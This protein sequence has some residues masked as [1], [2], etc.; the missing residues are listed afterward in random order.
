MTK[1]YYY[2]N[3]QLT[4]TDLSK[5]TGLS[6]ELIYSRLRNGDTVAQAVRGKHERKDPKQID[7]LESIPKAS[8]FNGI[9]LNK[10]D[11]IIIV[12]LIADYLR[13]KERGMELLE[14]EKRP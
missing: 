3:K 1:K 14:A 10:Q 9:D 4:I 13:K 7:L 2:R 5:L 6:Y 8:C 11:K 12:G